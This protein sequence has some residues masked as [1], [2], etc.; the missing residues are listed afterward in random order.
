MKAQPCY[1]VSGLSVTFIERIFVRKNFK[2]TKIYTI[3]LIDKVC[4]ITR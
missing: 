4:D 3:A 1:K 2:K